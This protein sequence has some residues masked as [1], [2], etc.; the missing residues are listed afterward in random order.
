MADKNKKAQMHGIEPK[1]NSK[2]EIISYKFRC[3]VGRDEQYKQVWRTCTISASDPRLE[4]LTP[5]KLIDEL[6][7]IKHEWDKA[8]KDDYNRTHSKIDKTKLTLVDFINNVWWPDHVMDGSHSPNSIS[9]YRFMAADICEYFGRKK[10][11]LNAINGETVKRYIKYLNTE[12]K[13]KILSTK[14]IPFSLMVKETGERVISWETDKQALS[15]QI[16]RYSKRSKDFVQI[17]R[18]DDLTYTDEKKAKEPKYQ[19]KALIR[20]EGDEPISKTTVVRHYQTL[21]NIL[22]F[23]QRFDYLKDDPCKKLSVKDKPHQGHKTIDFLAPKDARRYVQLLESQPLYWRCLENIL[24]TCGLRRGEAA[25]LQYGDFDHEKL[26]ITI[27]RSVCYDRNGINKLLIKGTKSGKSR[28]VSMT[29]R[30]SALVIKLKD[31]QE[32]KYNLTLSPTSYVFCNI[33]DPTRPLMVSDITR[34]Q[35]KFVERNGL[36]IVSPHDLRHSAASLALEAG[37]NLK[38]VQELLGHQDPETTSRFYA[39]LT[40]EAKRRTVTGI[41]NLLIPPTK[42]EK[43]AK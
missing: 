17:G 20:I 6:N 23:A 36:P 41:E 12:A 26:T 38:D 34:W 40:E 18:T 4:G 22:N 35:R 11:H 15:Y 7:S 14:E 31:E 1:K 25:G 8:Q 37:A 27:S 16:F 21:R 9:Y 39:G 43:E 30:I 29:A 19:V 2:G 5:K 10:T 32:Q 42:T 28:T 33:A 13:V 3:C 24:I